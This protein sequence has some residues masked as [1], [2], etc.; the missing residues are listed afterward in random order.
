[1]QAYLRA[2]IPRSSDVTFSNI[3][4][5]FGRKVVRIIISKNAPQQL[6]VKLRE[7][8]RQV[9]TLTAFTY[10]LVDNGPEEG[11]DTTVSLP[12]GPSAGRTQI[13]QGL[14]VLR[15]VMGEEKCRYRKGRIYKLVEGST[16]TFAPV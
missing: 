16:F 15:W 8:L 12:S 11:A 13:N 2:I 3:P 1:M 10:D 7:G 4:P 14:D 9:N 6:A 5:E